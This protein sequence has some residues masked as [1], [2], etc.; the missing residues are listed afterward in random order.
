MRLLTNDECRVIR[1][2]ISQEYRIGRAQ[3]L[4]PVVTRLFDE[5]T[6][7]RNKLKR[8]PKDKR[9]ALEYALYG[10]DGVGGVAREWAK[11]A[12]ELDLLMDDTEVK[13]A[14]NR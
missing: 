3:E 6:Q 1:R 13:R 11:Y 5:Y 2:E 14:I 9:K 4:L 12:A 10:E 8:T 7:L